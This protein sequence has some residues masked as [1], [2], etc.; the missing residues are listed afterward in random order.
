MSYGNQE[1]LISFEQVTLKTISSDLATL[2]GRKLSFP[3]N[4]A[5]IGDCITSNVCFEISKPF[6]F[7][8]M[9]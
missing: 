8:E 4:S 2:V 3:I 7:D 1:T 5:F 9:K 6:K